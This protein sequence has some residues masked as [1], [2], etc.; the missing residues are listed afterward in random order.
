MLRLKRFFEKIEVVHLINSRNVRC[1][2]EF[3]KYIKFR[4][5]HTLSI[6]EVHCTRKKE[7][8]KKGRKE[9]ERFLAFEFRKCVSRYKALHCYLETDMIFYSVYFRFKL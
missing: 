8:R 1:V 7:R 3:E 9:K 5:T 2:S 4:L 6:V